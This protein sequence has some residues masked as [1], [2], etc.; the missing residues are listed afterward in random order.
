MANQ[1]EPRRG[2][3]R[4][5]TGSAKLARPIDEDEPHA[6]AHVERREDGHGHAASKLEDVFDAKGLALTQARKGPT[7]SMDL[8]SA[9]RGERGGWIRRSR[10][11]DGSRFAETVGLR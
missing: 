10:T 8:L 5:T 1:P 4:L 9:D 6:V 11:P 7:R 2:R 3:R